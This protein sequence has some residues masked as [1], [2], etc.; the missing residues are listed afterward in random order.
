MAASERTQLSLTA[1]PQGKRLYKDAAQVVRRMHPARGSV[2]FV[3]LHILLLYP[4]PTIPTEFAAE[5]R[6]PL[7]TRR[8]CAHYSI[9]QPPYGKC[10]Y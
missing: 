9:T 8:C 4:D 2:T 10:A 1:A 3:P 5:W 6:L 7:Q